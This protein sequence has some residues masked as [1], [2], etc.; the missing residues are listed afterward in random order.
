VCFIIIR[1]VGAQVG[2]RSKERR[3]RTVNIIHA[4]GVKAVTG[5]KATWRMYG[6]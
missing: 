2:W 6:L 3:N 4:A 1:A 5:I